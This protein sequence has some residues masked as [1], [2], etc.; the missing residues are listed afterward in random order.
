[1]ADLPEYV[2]LVMVEG[3][4][5]V[6]A[7]ADDHP[8]MAER[9]EAEVWRRTGGASPPR[10]TAHAHVWR[11]RVADAVEMELLPA[12]IVKPS[13]RVQGAHDGQ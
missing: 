2:C 6:S 11:V 13:L 7:I 9:I 4:W 5:P 8:S 12:Q 3:E 1:M 10:S